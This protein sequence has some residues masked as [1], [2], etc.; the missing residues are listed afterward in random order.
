MIGHIVIVRNADEVDRPAIVLATG[1]GVHLVRVLLPGAKDFET[2]L[3]IFATEPEMVRWLEQGYPRRRAAFELRA[4][5]EPVMD[6]F[7]DELIAALKYGE[8]TQELDATT[9]T[10][11]PGE[12][13]IEV[14]EDADRVIFG[15]P[16]DVALDIVEDAK[17]LADELAERP[18]QVNRD[19]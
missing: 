16:I 1:K 11:A 19:E 3:P 15:E 7:E 2:E 8:R 14:V 9:R 17:Q 12:A 18:T 4:A 6:R 13:K 5:V 10:P